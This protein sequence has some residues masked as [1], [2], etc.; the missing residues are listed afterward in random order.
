MFRTSS[1]NLISYWWLKEI[2]SQLPYNYR[3]NLK[4]LIN[5]SHTTSN[6]W[7]QQKLISCEEQS[8]QKISFQSV[9]HCPSVPVDPGDYLVVLH[10]PCPSHQTQDSQH[11]RGSI[12]YLRYLLKRKIN[13]FP[14]E[15]AWLSHQLN[16]VWH[17]YVHTGANTNFPDMNR[18]CNRGNFD[19]IIMHN[20]V[21][22]RKMENF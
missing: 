3:K 17:S 12:L 9:L 14:G 1:E 16:G 21:V 11:S 2:Y 8:N 20:E 7:N 4:G 15:R 18:I 13:C 10:F 19:I 22:P 6:L 5:A